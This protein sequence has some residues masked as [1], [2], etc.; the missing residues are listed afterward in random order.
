MTATNM[1]STFVQ[2]VRAFQQGDYGAAA[3]H[4]ATV[5]ADLPD[6]LFYQHAAI[7]LNRVAEQGAHDIYAS[8]EGFAAFV[9]GGGNVPLY[10]E[11]S[12]RLAE[13]YASQRDIILLEIGVG[14]GLAL[15]PALTDTLAH[16][17]LVEPSEVMLATTRA[18]LQ[19][20]EIAHR[21]FNL[22]IET[23]IATEDRQY[24][25]A[26]AT[27]ALHNLAPAVR[28][29]L[30][31][32][33]Y[34][35]TDQLLIA[36]FDVRM[37]VA[38]NSADHILHLI[39]RYRQGL[40]EYTDS[41]TVVAQGFLLPILFRNFESADH[42][43]LHEQPIDDGIDELHAAGFTQVTKTHLYPYWWADAY[44]LTATK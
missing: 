20:H 39:E 34:R 28:A 12:K 25:I 37:D 24:D 21:A 35:H 14:D 22:P 18:A 17:D 41:Q 9:R 43:T 27:F 32:W 10:A 26:Q 38:L 1:R 31:E 19:Q 11:L 5:S 4:A 29:V 33:L 13:V 44:L 30:L 6:D 3:R 8:P 40:H 23:F 42:P 36:E 7:Y 2:A 16:I 15:L